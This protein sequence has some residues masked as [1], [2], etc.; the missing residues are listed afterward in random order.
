M[1]RAPA[2]TEILVMR[3]VLAVPVRPELRAI[4]V[5]PEALGSRAKWASPD[6]RE[7][8]VEA[9]DMEGPAARVNGLLV[10][11]SVEWVGLAARQEQVDSAE[12]AG[13]WVERAAPVDFP[14]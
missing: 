5:L 13:R 3:V 6:W 11:L 2:L 12:P 7:E 8:R 10:A 4:P 1:A 14:V 9:V